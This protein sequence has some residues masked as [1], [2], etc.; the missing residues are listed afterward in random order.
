MSC[1][2]LFRYLVRVGT[3][4]GLEDIV[5]ETEVSFKTLRSCFP[6]NLIHLNTYYTTVVALNNGVNQGC[7]NATSEGSELIP[8]DDT[9]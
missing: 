8:L 4:P 3:A 7:I 5:P 1:I 9:K 6:A 2:L